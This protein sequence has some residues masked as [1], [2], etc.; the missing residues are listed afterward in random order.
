ML[1][2]KRKVLRKQGRSEKRGRIK[3]KKKQGER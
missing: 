1:K 3:R 2:R